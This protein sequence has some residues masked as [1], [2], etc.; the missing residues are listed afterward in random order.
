MI[1]LIWGALEIF[2]VRKAMPLVVIQEENAWGFGQILP[3]LLL[4]L[5]VIGVLEHFYRV[6]ASIE[7]THEQSDRLQHKD[8]AEPLRT[9]GDSPY[10]GDEA[11]QPTSAGTSFRKRFY[12]QRYSS[13]YFRVYLW[14][15]N[16]FLLVTSAW[17]FA[18]MC[19]FGF[20]VVFSGRSSILFLYQWLEGF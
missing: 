4:V 17:T 3:L 14:S 19:L 13:R 11:M 16:I 10:T 8:R 12:D 1:G 20:N 9:Q 6:P 18:S 5:P 15:I 2:I 7:E